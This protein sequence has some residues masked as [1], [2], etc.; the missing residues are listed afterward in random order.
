MDVSVLILSFNHANY[1]VKA[2]EGVLQQRTSYRF[3]LLI[4]DDCS[5]DHSREIIKSYA[6]QYPHIIK[7]FYQENNLG[8]NQN[9]LFLYGQAQGKYICYCEADDFWCDPE[10]IQKQVDFL[11]RNSDFGLV[12]TDVNHYFLDT[13][14]E[15][16]AFNKCSGIEIPS[17]YIYDF[18]LGP[19]HSIKTMTVCLRRSILDRYYFDDPIIMQSP[20]A[21]VDI[22]L[23]LCIGQHAQ[24]KYMEDVTATYNLLEESMSRS[25]SAQKLHDFHKMIFD[26]RFYFSEKYT[27]SATVKKE[28]KRH[29]AAMMIGDAYKLKNKVLAQEGMSFANRNK[30]FLR[31]KDYVKFIILYCLN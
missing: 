20:W 5:T 17:G 7:A 2:I 29:Y 3:E 1:I 6:K 19:S 18:L 30:I 16:K 28:L 23:W 26:I 27:S 14:K 25:K 31:W 22:S 4:S 10:K 24:I 21:M 13:K 8:A 12:H 15:I 11:E 9:E